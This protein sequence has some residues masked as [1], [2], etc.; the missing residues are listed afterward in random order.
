MIVEIF[1]D[2]VVSLQP[3]YLINFMPGAVACT[4]NSTRLGTELPNGVGSI[5]VGGK[6]PL[7]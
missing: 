7:M 6:C 1:P 2:E 4:C 3:E 5:P